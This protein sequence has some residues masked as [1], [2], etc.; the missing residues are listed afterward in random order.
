MFI[1]WYKVLLPYVT[2]FPSVLIFVDEGVKSCLDLFL[3]V[4][5]KIMFCLYSFLSRVQKC[6]KSQNFIHAKIWLCKVRL[7]TSMDRKIAH[8]RQDG[9]PASSPWPD[10]RVWR[11]LTLERNF[12]SL[13]LNTRLLSIPSSIDETVV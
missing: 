10:K 2:I 11:N 13:L 9:S 12:N 6:A 5:Q 7:L 1:L 8:H 3:R 4:L